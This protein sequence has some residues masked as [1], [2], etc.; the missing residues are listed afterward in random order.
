MFRT[1]VDTNKEENITEESEEHRCV[2]KKGH[3][4]EIDVFVV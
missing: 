3:G 4:V 2:K 1:H